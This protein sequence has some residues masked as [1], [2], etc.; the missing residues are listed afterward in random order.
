MTKAITPEDC[1]IVRDLHDKG[2][3][4]SMIAL[5]FDTSADHV[6]SVLEEWF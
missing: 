2:L 4:D 3:S 1:R 5:R 6:K